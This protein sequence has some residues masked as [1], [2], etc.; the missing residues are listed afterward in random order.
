[1]DSHLEGIPCLRTLTARCLSSSD[2]KALGRESNG[3]FDAEILGLSTL[4]KFL[5]DLLER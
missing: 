1:V 5:A 3:A 2:L 4:D